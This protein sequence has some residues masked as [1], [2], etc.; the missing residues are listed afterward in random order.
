M[1]NLL[2]ED[3]RPVTIDYYFNVLIFLIELY[4]LNFLK[5]SSPYGDSSKDI[6]LYWIELLL[7][8]FGK[9]RELRYLWAFEG[10]VHRSTMR[11]LIISTESREKINSLVKYDLFMLPE[12]DVA[13]RIPNPA[14]KIIRIIES[15][16]ILTLSEVLKRYYKNRK[17]NE[18]LCYQEYKKF[19]GV[20]EQIEN[21]TS[22]SH[23]R[24]KK[25]LG[26]KWGTLRPY[27]FTNHYYDIISNGTCGAL[28]NEPEILNLLAKVI[29]DRLKIITS[30]RI[31][32]NKK[33][34]NNF[35][36]ECCNHLNIKPKEIKISQNKIEK[37]FDP[38]ED[39]YQFKI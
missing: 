32:P 9:K 12:E 8:G 19:K 26:N 21:E 3:L 34:V 16:T 20:V 22:E 39:P 27:E 28:K 29:K 4:K 10:L 24:L 35:I 14:E 11:L 37:Y 2:L 38:K 30:I 18:N 36:D 17:F 6:L 33:I 5:I 13:W 1:S 7:F 23:W 25:E 15:S 31:D